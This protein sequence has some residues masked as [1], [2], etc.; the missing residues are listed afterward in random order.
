MKKLS[1]KQKLHHNRCNA[2]KQRIE[3]KRKGHRK[4]Q[5]IIMQNLE[6]QLRRQVRQQAS[7]TISL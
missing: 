3:A 7:D 4:A 5:K 6:K 2:R 1:S